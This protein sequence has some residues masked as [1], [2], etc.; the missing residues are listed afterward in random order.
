[1]AT[2]KEI[3][4]QVPLDRDGIGGSGATLQAQQHGAD[5]GQRAGGGNVGGHQRLPGME[6]NRPA[7]ASWSVAPLMAITRRTCSAVY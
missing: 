7:T 6:G 4:A 3:T 1:M 5:R 2:G